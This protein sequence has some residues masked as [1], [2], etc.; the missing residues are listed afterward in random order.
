[1]VRAW[2]AAI[3]V[4]SSNA[5]E[6][7][8][9]DGAR[10]VASAGTPD[11]AGGAARGASEAPARPIRGA[12]G[13][14]SG[15]RLDGS[16]PGASPEASPPCNSTCVSAPP[17][18]WQGPY[19][20]Y[21]GMGS[22]LPI[23]PACAR[24]GAYSTDVY[25]GTGALQAGPAKCACD[26]G[27]VSGATCGS[28]VV[29]FYSGGDCMQSCSP[30]SQAIG[31]TCTTL[32][33]I[34][35]G[36]LHFTL[37]PGTPSGGCVPMSSTTLPTLEWQTNVRLCGMP[38]PPA[39]SGC[40]GGQLC[41]PTT[42]LPFESVYCV[43]RMGAWACPSAYPAQRT[44]YAS[45]VDSRACSACT[46]QAPTGIRCSA[47]VSTFGDPS[48]TGGLTERS[49]P[50]ACSGAGLKAAMTKE[51][52]AAGGSCAPSGGLASGTVAPS[53]PTTVCCTL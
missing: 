19:A 44:Y 47:T 14:F 7:L 26:C 27:P 43:A 29:N 16:V 9:D 4:L 41:A 24:A 8:V 48:C 15:E 28:P 37:A 25:D 18:S 5:C 33:V 2:P 12:D 23:P 10:S 42:G 50:A 52:K 17:A 36:G 51:T 20:I 22:P 31:S 46:C 53:T 3:L 49:A 38:S 34:G 1:M 40:E 6:L 11:A 35:C 32:N 39:T 21:E 13:G 30:A 45:Y